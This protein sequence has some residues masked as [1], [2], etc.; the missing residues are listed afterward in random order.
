MPTNGSNSHQ[1]NMALVQA[2]RDLSNS[3]TPLKAQFISEGKWQAAGQ[4]DDAQRDLLFDSTQLNAIDLTNLL[5]D[6]QA[7]Q[8]LQSVTASM[9]QASTTIANSEANLS[10]IV[11]IVSGAAQFVS[12]LSP[13]NAVA[14]GKALVGLVGLLRTPAAG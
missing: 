14:A 1:A 6:P 7:A 8:N 13:L 9:E 5:T 3:L 10:R 11:G 12:S 2:M 4:I